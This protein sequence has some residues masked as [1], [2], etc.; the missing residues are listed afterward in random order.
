MRRQISVQKMLLFGTIL[1]ILCKSIVALMICPCFLV[2]H[3]QIE[4][5]THIGSV[6]FLFHGLVPRV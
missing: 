5:V 3:L 4:I 1:L 2:H 6:I